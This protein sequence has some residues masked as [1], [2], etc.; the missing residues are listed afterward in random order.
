MY[1]NLNVYSPYSLTYIFCVKLYLPGLKH[2]IQ[3]T[4]QWLCR[5]VPA[6]LIPTQKDRHL[7]NDPH[8]GSSPTFSAIPPTNRGMMIA[9]YPPFGT[10]IICLM[11]P[12]DITKKLRIILG[13]KCFSL[14]PDDM[15]T[16]YLPLKI[17]SLI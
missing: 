3:S 13:Y 2:F 9:N 6:L 4:S 17:I 7:H 16:L 15:L 14:T 5:R 10:S 11:A 8:C 1:H 12:V